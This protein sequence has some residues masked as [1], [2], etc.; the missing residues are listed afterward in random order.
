MYFRLRDE[1]A[2]NYDTVELGKTPAVPEYNLEIEDEILDKFDEFGLSELQEGIFENSPSKTKE[3]YRE[4]LR[5]LDFI[6]V[7]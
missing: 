4:F 2:W 5:K 1:T 6:E 7:K 3:E